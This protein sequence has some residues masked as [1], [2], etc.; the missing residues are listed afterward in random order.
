MIPCEQ[1]V[2][3]ELGR[4]LASNELT[5]VRRIRKNLTLKVYRGHRRRLYGGVL[6]SLR[7]KMDQFEPSL[8]GV[9]MSFDGLTV[10]VITK[11]HRNNMQ[12]ETRSTKSRE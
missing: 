12:T 2:G 7:D 9:L 4:D 1:L 5:G 10:L 8:G 11:R 3:P 6:L